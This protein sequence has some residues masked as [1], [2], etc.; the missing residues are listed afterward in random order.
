MNESRLP[1]MIMRCVISTVL[2]IFYLLFEVGRGNKILR[3][4][5]TEIHKSM[6]SSLYKFGENA[7]LI[8]II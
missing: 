2:S 8:L 5:L 3:S 4:D 7:V 6:N 1:G